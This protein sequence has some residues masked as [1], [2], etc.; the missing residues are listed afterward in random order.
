M[1]PRSDGMRRLSLGIV[2]P[3]FS[4]VYHLER[5]NGLLRGAF[6][7]SQIILTME[8][9]SMCGICGWIRPSGLELRPVVRMNRLASHR[10]PD[11]EGY[12]IW[13]GHSAMGQ[14]V[15]SRLA[16]QSDHHGVVAIGSHRLAILELYAAGR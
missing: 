11:D 14:F 13:D 3:W 7:S 10:G 6:I 9:T 15:E 2:D 16:D 1:G 5:C 8:Y 4:M 12:W